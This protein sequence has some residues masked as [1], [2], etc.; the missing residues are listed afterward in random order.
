VLAVEHPTIG[1]DISSRTLSRAGWGR[2]QSARGVCVELSD[3]YAEWAVRFNRGLRRARERIV[4][5][6]QDGAA[7]AD[8]GLEAPSYHAVVTALEIIERLYVRERCP[9][10]AATLDLKGASL[11]TGGEISLE[12]ARGSRAL[13]YRIEPDGTVVALLFDANKLIGT[14][15]LVA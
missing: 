13:T 8:E 1:F 10:N 7:L 15:L 4:L 2:P 11:G 6:L 5:W 14:T 3:P 9:A 12:F